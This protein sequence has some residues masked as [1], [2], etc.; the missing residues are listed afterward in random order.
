MARGRGS[1]A[2]GDGGGRERRAGLGEQPPNHRHQQ[3]LP[4]GGK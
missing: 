1:G 3:P 4:S 2:G